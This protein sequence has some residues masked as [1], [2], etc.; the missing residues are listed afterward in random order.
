MLHFKFYQ[1]IQLSANYCMCLGQG[2]VG[3]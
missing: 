1:F 3:L 2:S